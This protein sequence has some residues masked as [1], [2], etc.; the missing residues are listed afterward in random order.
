MR[1]RFKT[2]KVDYKFISNNPKVVDSLPSVYD[3]LFR[4]VMNIEMQKY[5]K[6]IKA[7]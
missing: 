2:F 5:G 1:K 3:Y 7:V 4:K 6:N